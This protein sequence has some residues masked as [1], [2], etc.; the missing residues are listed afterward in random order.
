MKVKINGS[1]YLYFN[2]F[3]MSSNLDSVASTFAFTLKYDPKNL[4]LKELVRPLSFH[5]VEFI[6][7]ETGELQ[8]TGIILSHTFN[9]RSTPELVQLSGYSLA[10]E[11][12]DCSIPY[13][14]Y[15]LESLNRTLKEIATRLLQLFNLKL[16]ISVNVKKECDQIYT[17]SVA[18][19]S[20]SIKEYLA[21]LAAQ[22]NVVVSHDPA[23]N[24]LFFRP[25]TKVA[26]KGL[27]DQHN[28]LNMGLD[29]NGQGMHSDLTSIRQP[30][31]KSDS[32][33]DDENEGVTGVDSIKNPLV[34]RFRPFVEVLSSGTETDTVKGVKNT[35]AAELKNIK[36]GFELSKWDN[37]NIGDVLEVQNEEL[38]ISWPVRMIIVSLSKIEDSQ[39]K[40]MVVTLVLPETFTGEQP[41]NIF[42]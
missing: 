22:R 1:E 24:V 6:N 19:P 42:S 2:D 16:V 4:A 5:K 14:S 30:S 41:K 15:P 20:G 23:G 21:K 11:L 25:D 39:K 7:E 36:V 8:L 32:D 9:S 27:Y 12:E 33:F 34:K 13:S 29:V 28:T 35:L 18:T 17:K 38:F 40:S 26:S 10:G 31:K 3:T 37:I